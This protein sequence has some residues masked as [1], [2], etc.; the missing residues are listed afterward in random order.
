MGI[1][2]QFPNFKPVVLDMKDELGKF[3]HSLKCGISE[4]SFVNLFIDSIKYTY[5]IS[6]VSENSIV[7]VGVHPE[8]HFSNYDLSGDFF[9]V[10]GELPTQEILLQLF[11]HFKYWKNMSEEIFLNYGTVLGQ[12][13]LIIL[14][15][16]DNFDYLYS[17]TELAMLQGK[18]F[19]KK[20]NLVNAFKSNYETQVKTLDVYSLADAY[21]VLESW[22][23]S[24]T[25][26][27]LADYYQ[28]KKTLDLFDKL[29]LAG[30]VVYADGIPVGFSLG[31][32]I[33]NE[34]MFVVMFEKGI[35]SYKG[36]YQ[37]VNQAQA[38]ALLPSTKYIN[39]EQDLGDTGLRQAKMTYRPCGFTKKYLA[40][41]LSMS[42]Q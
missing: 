39:R 36:V 11:R 1:I 13:G 33:L 17:R 15:D 35:N 4:F 27:S 10:L 18:N 29:P 41:P 21:S 38:L 42:R 3:C 8:R 23:L 16:R 22:K 9:S 25:Q 12:K 28:C 32:Y 20:K 14:E 26:D 2:P 5:K 19:H 24:R 40:L 6:C 34:E 31:E 30:V 37:F 7:I